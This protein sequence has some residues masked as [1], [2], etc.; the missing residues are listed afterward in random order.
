MRV[1]LCALLAVAMTGCSTLELVTPSA[2]KPW[3]K[4]YERQNLADEIM[5]TDRFPLDAAF[6]A[7]LY[8]SRE[9]SRGA[10][11]GGGGGCGCN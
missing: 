11:G 6:M 1:A 5:T 7:H 8:N 9:G 4:P 2:P 3:V 10:E